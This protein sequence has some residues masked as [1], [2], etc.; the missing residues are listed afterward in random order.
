MVLYGFLVTRTLSQLEVL[1][2]TKLFSGPRESLSNVARSILINDE[3]FSLLASPGDNST[4]HLQFRGPQFRCTTANH[5]ITVPLDGTVY[6]NGLVFVSKWES[7]SLRYSIAQH[8][9]EVLR[10]NQSVNLTHY[11]IGFMEQSC[12]TVSMLYD[13][14]VSFPRGLR[15]IK[16]SCSNAEPFE[17]KSRMLGPTWYIPSPNLYTMLKLPAEAQVIHIWNQQVISLIPIVNQWA[18]SDAMGELLVGEFYDQYRWVVQKDCDV[19]YNISQLGDCVV[20]SSTERRSHS[21][22]N[23]SSKFD[24][25]SSHLLRLTNI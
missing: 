25:Y 17:N 23:L 22:S 14:E 9:I 20:G 8:S 4:Y 3:V 10:N 6:N 2:Q 18:L 24:L 5:N 13:V 19:R 12:E 7:E 15:Q 16:H 11:S 21:P 1:I